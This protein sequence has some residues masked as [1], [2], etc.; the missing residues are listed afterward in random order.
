[1]REVSIRF[2]GLTGQGIE[3]AT[4]ILA[5]ACVLKGLNIHTYRWF[6][7]IVRGGYTFSEIRISEDPV[8][9]LAD[10]LDIL[11]LLD[12][13]GLRDLEGFLK[14]DSIV[15]VDE[16]F[17]EVQLDAKIIKIPL[18][19]A[20]IETKS[21][22][23]IIAIGFIS[24]LLGLD[25]MDI[26]KILE[27]KIK[28]KELLEFNLKGL[29]SGY[30]IFLESGLPDI[31]I[32]GTSKVKTIVQGSD[33]VALAA[34]SAGC[35]F[36]A[37]YPITPSTGIM[38]RLMKWMPEVGGLAVQVE[39]ELAAIN[40]I[41]GASYAGARA[42]TVTSGPGFSLMVEGIGFAAM[43]EV[44]IVVVDVQRVGPSTGLPT[45]HEQ[46]DIDLTTHPSHGD[47]P[48]IVLAPSIIEEYYTMTVDAF[49]LADKYRCPVILLLDQAYVMNY[50]SI[51]VLEVVRVSER[52]T[53]YR[54]RG[55]ILQVF[56]RYTDLEDLPSPPLE[57][58]LIVASSVEHDERGLS[59]QDGLVH[60]EMSIRRMKKLRELEDNPINWEV[61]GELD[62]CEAI[63][64]VGSCRPAVEE[65]LSKI[66]D[67]KIMH[68]PLKQLWPLPRKLGEV[69]ANIEKVYVVEQNASG[70][71]LNLISS[72][73]PKSSEVKSI[74][75]F[76]GHPFRPR[77]IYHEIV[78]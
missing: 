76:D 67:K 38:E 36:F 50:Y 58:Y 51:D 2:S 14:R 68:I 1:M 60:V 13:I 39:D 63:V 32:S 31:K 40:M 11:I 16:D 20:S 66:K 15:I 26:S 8:K 6:P 69:L 65:A 75:K 17:R 49:K 12:E 34:L 71:L 22:S 45:A 3:F 61:L 48:R 33:L 43:A 10:T 59:S 62:A 74:R 53:V 19:R 73:I 35:K 72:K 41:I 18:R 54:P 24:G 9:A 30:R 7:T 44:P 78:E 64:S 70:Q 47:I 57:G 25:I 56:P 28:K 29:E 37:G 55:E 42:M 4:E 77:E 5:E 21:R 46:S 27:K 52:K 23:N